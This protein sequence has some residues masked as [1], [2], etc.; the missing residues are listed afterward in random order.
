MAVARI[1]GVLGRW[2]EDQA[3][4]HVAHLG[5]TILDRNWRC[6]VGE[7]DLVGRQPDGT[8][9][10]IEVKTRSGRGYGD[11]LEAVT[12]AKVRKL[13]EL[14]LWWLRERNV[15]ARRVRIDAIGLVRDRDGV[16]LTHV[17]GI[18]R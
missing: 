12:V 16:D 7:L 6:P 11:P 10:F 8:I 2:G 13:H 1:T 3:A 14:A 9:V 18:T 4:L 15:S 17:R 5:W